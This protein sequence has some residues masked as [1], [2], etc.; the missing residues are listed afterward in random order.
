M[1]IL[2]RAV[3]ALDVAL[4]GYASLIGVLFV[5]PAGVWG[6]LVSTPVVASF[7]LGVSSLRLRSRRRAMT[8][9][10][11]RL[12]VAVVCA[13]PVMMLFAG[14]TVLLPAW[15]VAASPAYLLMAWRRQRIA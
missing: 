1:S 7:V 8:A 6:L 10:G 11:A 13:Y 5:F 12:V 4:V 9:A 3:I 14:G 2:L 15:L